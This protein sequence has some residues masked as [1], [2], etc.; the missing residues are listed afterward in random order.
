MALAAMFFISIITIGWKN[1]FAV[2]IALAGFAAILGA[3][4]FQATYRQNDLAQFYGQQI[5]G[6][7]I[8]TEEPDVRSDKVYLTLG[9]VEIDS[10]QLSSK[11]LATVPLFPEYEYGQKLNFSGK[12]QEP[13][14][15]PDFNYK[16]YLSR[17]GIDAVTYYP[18]VSVEAGNFG[19]RTK[20]ALL[21]LKR[22]FLA[23]LNSM[24]PEPQASF[25]GGLL[26]GARRAI[27]QSLIDQFNATSTSH[28]IA[29]S[30]YNI[31]IIA[32]GIAGLLQ[33]FGLRKRVSFWIST[34]A[35]VGFV[36]MAGASASVVRAGIMGLLV[37]LARNIGRLYAAANALV[38]TA[39]AMLA[40]NPQI[41][42]FDVG[43]QL[44]FVAVLGLVYLIPLIEKYFRWAPNFLSLREILTATIAAQIFTLP[45]LLYYFG[46]LSVVAIPVNILVLIAIPITML[47][48]F[49]AGLAG[50]AGSILAWPFMAISWLML[51]YIIKVVGLFAAI[52]FAALGLTIN[53]YGVWIYYLI[54]LGVL[55]WH[56]KLWP[57]KLKTSSNI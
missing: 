6:T 21:D 41:L 30:G 38:L 8:V 15:F 49:L 57:L 43:F 50:F 33:W 28:I 17:F 1:K 56:Y 23:N 11:I 24:L 46:R 22:K 45:L 7:A 27:P 40:I 55:V 53:I 34:L 29:L 2:V 54:L 9:H 35:I 36:I 4:R 44:S 16:N 37:L 26:L 5:S 51:T 52:P 12:L 32:I 18:K 19:N 3:I 13:K 31:S 14:E 10:Q 25:M 42:H 39:V 20:S 47:F 48:G